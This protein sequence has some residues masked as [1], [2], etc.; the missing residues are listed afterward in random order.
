MNIRRMAALQLGFL[1]LVATFAGGASRGNLIQIKVLDSETRSV[2]DDD[3]GIP[4][5]CEQITFDA[6]CRSTSTPQMTSTLLVQEGN[7]PPFR[8]TCRIESEFSRCTPMPKGETFEASREKHG[9]TIYYVDDKGKAQKQSYKFVDKGAKGAKAGPSATTVAVATQPVPAAAENAGQPRAAAV[10]SPVQNAPAP[11][12]APAPAQGGITER[13]SR[14]S[15][16]EK[17]RCNFTSSPPDA[18]ITI[19][20]SYVGNTPSEIGLTTGKHIVVIAKVGF[21]E[22]KRELTV[23]SDSVVNVT[24]NLQ[25]QP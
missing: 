5:N 16:R 11:V 6:Y 10:A 14:Q 7:D 9:I 25:T 22:W 24:A 13:A 2:G 4:I 3:N 17:V 1:L 23:A 20:G 15:T 12:P 8:V 18:D 21:G 19:D